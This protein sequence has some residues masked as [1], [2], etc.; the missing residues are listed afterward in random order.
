MKTV[1]VL[2]SVLFISACTDNRVC[3]IDQS[4]FHFIK[5]WGKCPTEDGSCLLKWRTKGSEDEWVLSGSQT[6]DR[7]AERDAELEYAC[8]CK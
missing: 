7:D 1:I 3:A 2:I 4:S 5:C 6:R 8:Y